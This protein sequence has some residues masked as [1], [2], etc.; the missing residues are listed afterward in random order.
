MKNF[1]TIILAILIITTIDCNKKASNPR[2]LSKSNIQKI[3][4]L[5]NF[6]IDSPTVDRYLHADHY[7][8]SNERRI[9]LFTS[10]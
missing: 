10:S 6:E 9:D 8:A 7:P 5:S 4:Q 3:F 1:T 2:G